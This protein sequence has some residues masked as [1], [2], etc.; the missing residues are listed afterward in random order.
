M[1][2]AAAGLAVLR[3]ASARQSS[4]RTRISRSWSRCSA[5]Q[6]PS[7]PGRNVRRASDSA[8]D[9]SAGALV[10]VVGEGAL[11]CVCR[12]GRGD[13]VNPGIRG[14]RELVA[15]ERARQ[16]LHAVEADSVRRARSLLTRTESAFSQVAGGASP[17][18]ASA[19]SSRGT[20]RP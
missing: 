13:Q 1:R 17:Q 14:K 2:A 18:S 20:G 7:S 19:S 11:G 6:R 15:A 16:C 12:F 8:V 4:A 10:G 3:L 5:T 9:A